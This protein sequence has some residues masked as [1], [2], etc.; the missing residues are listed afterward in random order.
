MPSERRGGLRTIVAVIIIVAVVVG[1]L[2][3]VIGTGNLSLGGNP[4]TTATFSASGTQVTVS[5]SIVTHSD[6]TANV[7][8]VFKTIGNGTAYLTG[9]EIDAFLVASYYNGLTPPVGLPIQPGSDRTWHTTVYGGIAQKGE[10]YQVRVGIDGN[11]HSMTV[12]AS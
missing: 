1:G 2:A 5:A 3:Y 11:W 9:V 8:L 10:G 7:T 12:D 4:S 6:G